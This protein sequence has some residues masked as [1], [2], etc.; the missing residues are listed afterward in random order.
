MEK[1]LCSKSLLKNQLAREENIEWI[2]SIPKLNKKANRG[3]LEETSDSKLESLVSWLNKNN[4]KKNVAIQSPTIYY[5]LEEKLWT[6]K[7]K[8]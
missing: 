2:Q 8:S 6:T 7:Q 4:E 5:Q 1:I 3:Q